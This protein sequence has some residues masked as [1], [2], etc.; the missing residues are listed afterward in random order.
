MKTYNATLCVNE[1][2]YSL[3]GE[4]TRTGFPSLFIRLAGCNLNC[5]WCD[6][7]YAR[8]GST[9]TIANIIQTIE[10]YPSLHHI[11]ITGGEPLVQENTIAL[12]EI[13]CRKNV[14]LQLETNGSI[15]V[16]YVPPQVHK[17]IDVKTPSSGHADSF[18]FSNIPL[19]SPHD[20]IKFVIADD[21]DYNYSK[22]F[23][24]KYLV[25]VPCVINF[26]PV[27]GLMEPYTLA[28]YILRD[29]MKVRFNIQ[30][31]KFLWNTEPKHF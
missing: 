7:P 16:E 14:P 13:L 29:R 17:I 27:D 4:T 26:S 24:K 9:V 18:N 2:F 10:A 20:E 12:L 28:E 19:L 11:T 21:N 31:H 5:R 25:D 23:I 22:E 15:S 30:L 3:Q 1:I 6:T 8:T